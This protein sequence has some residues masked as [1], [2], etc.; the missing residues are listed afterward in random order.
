MH[1]GYG[2]VF[3]S[4][5][6][7]WNPSLSAVNNET[8]IYCK[9]CRISL[10]SLQH[11]DLDWVFSMKEA[12]FPERVVIFHIT[13]LWSGCSHKNHT[14]S[15]WQAWLLNRNLNLTGEGTGSCCRHW[16]SITQS[17]TDLGERKYSPVTVVPMQGGHWMWKSLPSFRRWFS[18]LV[19]PVI[20]LYF[21]CI[22]ETW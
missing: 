18:L 21:S 19:C 2:K 7:R 12:V 4:P 6:A 20:S 17:S 15:E 8:P 16:T 10:K 9:C 1:A 11:S 14:S 3:C 22:Q 13:Q 5:A